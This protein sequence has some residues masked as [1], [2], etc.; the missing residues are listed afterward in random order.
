MIYMKEMSE[1][2]LLKIDEDI[3]KESRIHYFQVDALKAIMIF[4]VI[5]DHMV[6]WGVKSEI[7]VALWE[8]ICIPV[9]LVFMG[10]NMGLSFQRKGALTLRELYSKSYFKRKIIRYVIPFLLLY[11]VSTII[12]LLMYNFNF[13]N[14]Y[15]EQYSPEWGVINLF[16]GI[17]PFWGPGNWFIPVILQS[18]LIL[19]ILYKGFTKKPIL[20]LILC[21]IIEITMQLIVF[22]LIGEITSWEEAHILSLFMT[23]VLFYLSAIGLGMWFSFGYKLKERRNIFIWILF[24]ISL[25][26]LI[27]YQFF[28]FRLMINGIPLLRGDYH[29]LVFP[30]SA[31]LFLLAMML[32]PQK[33]EGKFGRILSLIGKSTYHILLIQILGFGIMVAYYGTH[34]M[35]NVGFPLID[36][37]NLPVVWILFIS[38]GIWWY[39]ID[40]IKNLK[41]R[42][43]YTIALF[44]IFISILW[45]LI[46]FL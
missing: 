37:L 12:G 29:F 43:I 36:L 39:K 32:L 45:V 38:F 9:F 6:S 35:I 33:S 20:T 30:Y 16:T 42:V 40:K 46:V 31:F 7:G 5:F 23:S 21:F 11:A 14:M 18:I 1:V 44:T 34:Y 22:T 15:N 26:Y 28:G 4:L 10:F 3:S 13:A 25:T 17:L 19:P 24:P 27:M 2:F 8:R 41:R